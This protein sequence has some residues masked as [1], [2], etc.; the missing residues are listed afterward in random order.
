[1]AEGTYEYE[2]KRAELLGV[3]PPNQT[4]WE[5][6]ER[7]RKESELAQQMAVRKIENSNKS[8]QIFEKIRF[9]CELSLKLKN[10][11]SNEKQT[12]IVEKF[13]TTENIAEIF[14]IFK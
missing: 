2:C 7:V 10:Q 13:Q 11:K 8:N 14:F 1:M 5:E 12:K 3:D 9:F 6:A 4:D